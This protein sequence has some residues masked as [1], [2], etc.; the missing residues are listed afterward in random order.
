MCLLLKK[1]LDLLA[2]GKSVNYEG[3]SNVE[4]TEVGESFGS[5]LV[6]LF[7]SEVITGNVTFIKGHINF[8]CNT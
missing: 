1:A 7:L 8:S 3:A 5:F 2:Q 4:F 6:K